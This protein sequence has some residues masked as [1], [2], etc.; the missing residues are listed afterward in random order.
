MSEKD[1]YR[2]LGVSRGAS[3]EEIKKSYRSLAR[4]YHPDRNNSPGA[5]ARFKE[6]SA[7]FAVLGDAGKRKVYDEFGADGLREGFDAEAA[8]NY[9]KWSGQFGGFG[10][11]GGPH[12]GFGGGLGGFGDL[13]DLLGNLFG[14]GGAGFS[15]SVRRVGRNVERKVTLS[16]RQACEG[17]ELRL[18]ELGGQI[19]LPQGAFEGQKLRLAGKGEAGAGGRGDLILKLAIT[20][21]PGFERRGPD[22]YMDV[23]VTPL[24]AFVGSAVEV[25][26]PEGGLMQIKIPPRSQGGR[27][28]RIRGRG[29]PT[30]KS[31]RGDVFFQ[32]QV[33]IPDGDDPQIEALLTDLEVFFEAVEQA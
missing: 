24:Q 7:A 23:P 13:E 5:E 20:T 6:I 28:L 31:I 12:M 10:G 17:G 22:L 9:Q 32:M 1:L 2:I 3:P 15:Q 16:V 8:R 4:T 26:T 21:P 29:M 14:G 11:G 18:A 19:K 30:D 25:P 33:R 27:R